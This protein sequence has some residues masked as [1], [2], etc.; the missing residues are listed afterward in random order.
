MSGSIVFP[1]IVV[2]CIQVA[3]RISLQNYSVN[4]AQICSKVR[5]SRNSHDVNTLNEQHT[6][7]ESLS[8]MLLFTTLMHSLCDQY[9]VGGV[10]EAFRPPTSIY[11]EATDQEI[12]QRWVYEIHTSI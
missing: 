12:L 4:D 6:F 9:L 1:H 10:W 7:L 5:T 2:A 3:N 8:I 11:T